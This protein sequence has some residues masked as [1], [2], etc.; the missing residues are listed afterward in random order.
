MGPVQRGEMSGHQFEKRQTC[1]Q[2]KSHRAKKSFPRFLWTDVWNQRVPPNNAAG[3]V[4]ADV[5]ELGDRDQIKAGKLPH[6]RTGL[7]SRYDIK[8][9]GHGNKKTQH[10]EKCEEGA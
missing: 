1:Q 3:K 9:V 5:A 2:R 7:R 8:N 10:V 4:G 6:N